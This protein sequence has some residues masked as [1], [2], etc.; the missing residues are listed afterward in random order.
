MRKMLWMFAMICLYCLILARVAHAQISA[1]L[2]AQPSAYSGICPAE[3]IFRG[4]IISE[5]RGKVQYKFIRNDGTLL[6]VETLEF[7]TPGAKEVSGSW[8]AADA[9]TPL[10]EG[11]QAIRIV[12]PEKVES[13][14][15]KFHLTCDQTT[16]GLKVKIQRSPSTARPGHE[17]GSSIKVNVAN[18]SQFDLKNITIDIL[19]KKD[20]SC[21]VSTPN[22][23]DSTHSSDGILLEGG[24]DRV[25]LKAGQQLD[26]KLNRTNTIAADT[27][28]G[29][30]YMCAMVNTGD[31]IKEINKTNDCACRPI[32]I[33]TAVDKPDLIIDRISFKV[34][35]KCEPNQPIYIFEVTVRNIGTAPSPS[36]PNKTLVQVMDMHGNG[37]G[38]GATLNSLP[39]GGTQTVLIPV[40]YFSEDPAHMTKAVPHPFRAVVDPLHLIE[41]ANKKNNTSDIIYLDPGLICPK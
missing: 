20:N 26:I 9:S 28:I 12:Y 4:T 15:A 7:S 33:T 38:N 25:F 11:W 23:V 41:E 6:P 16:P 18:Q 5:K 21:S 1:T 10:F 8:M 3:I 13:N 2:S 29:D 30:Y 14:A 17:L 22:A 36:L 31:Q 34:G 35:E 24:H 37:W 40:Y 19:L 39:P 27:P 32:K